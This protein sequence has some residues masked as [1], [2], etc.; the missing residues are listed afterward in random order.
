MS[1]HQIIIDTRE[2]RPWRFKAPSRRG[3]LRRGDYSLVGLEE[4]VAIERK[5]LPDLAG[6][7]TH[8]RSRFERAL[9]RLAEVDH[10]LIVVEGNLGDF[11]DGV[12]HRSCA[13]P[14]SLLG[15]V[16]SIVL[17]NASR[18]PV[19]IIFAEDRETAARFVERFL[20]K[21]SSRVAESRREAEPLHHL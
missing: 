10:P 2:R 3:T 21:V 15:S 1:D 19:P 20:A 9:E 7:L 12:G 17:G 6:S 16:V 18:G 4:V 14:S 8:G 13:H 11:I 5:S